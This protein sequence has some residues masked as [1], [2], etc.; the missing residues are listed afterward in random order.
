MEIDTAVD[1]DQNPKSFLFSVTNS[2]WKNSIRKQ[3]RHHRIA[4]TVSIED[5]QINFVPNDVDLEGEVF[6]KIRNELLNNL[7]SSLPDKVRTPMLLYYA[8]EFPLDEIASILEI[9]SGTVKSRLYKG[10]SLIKKGLEEHGYQ[11]S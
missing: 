7:L 3:A 2:I 10:R 6:S 11:Y 1:W 8:F 4:P 9:P 5:G